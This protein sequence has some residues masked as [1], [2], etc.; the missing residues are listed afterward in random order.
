MTKQQQRKNR[1]CK[2]LA[3]EAQLPWFHLKILP[4]SELVRE[5]NQFRDLN[6]KLRRIQFELQQTKLK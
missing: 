6:R 5:Y 2:A 3:Y 4:Y 1:I